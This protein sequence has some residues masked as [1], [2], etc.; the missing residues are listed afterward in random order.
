MH[1]RVGRVG[2]LAGD[3]AVRGLGCQL[4][5]LGDSSLHAFRA[6]G[7]HQ[8]CAVSLEQIAALNAHRLGH[9]QYDLVAAGSRDGSQT[10]AGVAAGRLDDYRAG[11]QLALGLGIVQHG[12]GYTILYAARRIEVLQLDQYGGLQIMRLFIIAQLKQ[13]GVADK[14]G[15]SLKNFHRDFSLHIKTVYVVMP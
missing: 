6:L 15:Y 10:Y 8:L 9:G 12:L 1:L 11:L 13:G 2:E 4:L 3:E 7:Q 5:R 14:I